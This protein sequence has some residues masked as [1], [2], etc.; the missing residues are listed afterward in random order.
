MRLRCVECPG[1]QFVVVEYDSCQPN[2]RTAQMVGDAV[3]ELRERTGAPRVHLIADS[4]GAISARWCLRVGE[5]R[6]VVDQLVTPSGCAPRHDL[7]G[8]RAPPVL[9][10]CVR[11]DMQTRIR[12][13]GLAQRG[14]GA[15]GVS[16]SRPGR[17]PASSSSCPA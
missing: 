8:R 5:C 9:G 12:G 2:R 6:G 7:G 15:P 4:M 1:D 3:A 17:P 16:G 13:P 11:P 10:Q 14:R